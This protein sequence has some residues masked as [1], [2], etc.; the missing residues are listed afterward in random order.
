[1]AYMRDARGDLRS[2]TARS[3]VCRVPS[4]GA[5]TVHGC[6]AR[7]WRWWARATR[8][9]HSGGAFIDRRGGTNPA[10]RARDRAA[11]RAAAPAAFQG[12]RQRSDGIMTDRDPILSDPPRASTPGRRAAAAVGLGWLRWRMSVC[13]RIW[14]PLALRGLAL[15][16]A[17]LGLAG[18]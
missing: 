12:V 13:W 10:T 18:I 4:R 2:R 6:A 17:L 1:M 3:D 5:G 11:P 16:I 15:G 8:Q 7:P 9:P 14:A